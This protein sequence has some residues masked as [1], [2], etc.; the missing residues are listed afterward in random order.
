[1]FSPAL[2]FSVGSTFRIER[3]EHALRHRIRYGGGE[4]Q[5]STFN[6]TVQNPVLTVTSFTPLTSGFAVTF[7]RP[8]NTSLLNLYD[9]LIPDSVSPQNPNGINNS[10]GA[11]DVTLVGQNTAAVRG[12]LVWNSA[13]DTASFVK[14]DAVARTPTP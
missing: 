12:S 14:T 1:M 10:F 3:P 6:V 9:G 4:R 11:A 7:N 13:T 5:Y 8:V 2:P